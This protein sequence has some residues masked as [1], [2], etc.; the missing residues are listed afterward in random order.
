MK[1]S[2]STTVFLLVLVVGCVSSSSNTTCESNGFT[3]SADCSV[4]YRCSGSSSGYQ[5]V[6]AVRCDTSKGQYCNAKLGGCSETPQ[7]C[8]QTRASTFHCTQQGYFP[9]PY[10]CTQY[11]VCMHY[12]N[13][14]PEYGSILDGRCESGWAY[15]PVTTTCKYLTT[16][17]VCTEGVVPRCSYVGQN[18][19]LASD[20]MMFYICTPGSNGEIEPFIY[21]CPHGQ[22]YVTGTGC[23]ASPDPEPPVT[24]AVPPIVNGCTRPG[25]F[26]DPFNCHRYYICTDSLQKRHYSCY[27]GFYFSQ[28]RQRC[29]FGNC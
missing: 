23:T 13:S 19:P 20:P 8:R 2:S 6:E 26:A 9:D 28:S 17:K 15:D 29:I 3:C 10:D 14:I 12:P 4:L 18:G 22:T 21:E 16:D 24:T 25:I 5:Q 27:F 1:T 11:H 7:Y